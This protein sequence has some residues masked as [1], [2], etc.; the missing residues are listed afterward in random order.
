LPRAARSCALLLLCAAC[1]CAFSATASALPPSFATSGARA[2]QISE[3]LGGI[4]IDQES[5]DVYIADS[6]NNR[7]EKFSGEG[8]F[9]L[10]FGWGVADGESQEL[11]TC[12]TICFKGLEGAGAGEFVEPAGIAVDNDP[13][14]LSHGDVYVV[15][16]RNNRVQK[17]DSEGHFLTMFGGEVNSSTKANICPAAEAAFCQAG[18]KGT[19]PG[20]FEGLAGRAVAVDEST[21]TVY[22]ADRNRIQRFSEEGAAESEITF[23]EETGLIR[24]LAIDSAKDIYLWGDLQQGVHKYDQSGAELGTPRDTEAFAEALAITIGPGDELLLND[25]RPEDHHIFAF[26]PGGEQSASFDRGDGSADGERG[27]AYSTVTE[28]IYVLNGEAGRVRILTQPP[29]GP[30]IVLESQSAT[31]IEPTT[32][33]LNALAN[34]EGPEVSKCRFQYGTSTAYGSETEEKELTSGFEDQPL[35]AQL[36]G[37]S[38]NTTYHFRATCE[39]AAK[40]VGTGADESFTTLPPVSIDQTSASQ[41]NATSARLEAELNPHGLQS[42][43]RFEYGRSTAYGTS[44]PV[45]D[46]SFGSSSTDTAVENLI[47]ELLPSTTYH[48]RVIAHNALGT[49]TGPDRSFTTQGESSILPD[50]RGW[51]M[52]SPPNKHG[53]PVEPLTAAGGLIQTSLAGGA[54]AYVSD[55]PVDTDPPANRSPHDTQLIATRTPNGWQTKDIATPHEE[56]SI[57]NAGHPSEYKFWAEDLHASIVEPEGAEPLSA[58]TTERTPYRREADGEYVP[59]IT[60][61]NVPAGVEFGGKELSAENG[62]WIEGVNFR[63]AT[64]DLAHVVLESPQAL[65]PGFGPGFEPGENSNLYELTNGKL[66]LISVLPNGKPTAEAGV[67]AAVALDGFSMRGAIANDG[68]RVVFETVGEHRYL[69]DVALGQTLQLDVRQPGAAGGPFEPRFQAAN[70]DDSK[71]LFTDEAALT[72]DATATPNRPDLYMCEVKV[73]A[74][75]LSCAL[76]DLSVDHNPGEAANVAGTVSAI[77]AS[78]QHVYFAADGVLTHA[79][80]IR[81][82]AAVPGSCNSNEESTC[83]LYEYDTNTHHLGLVAV[84]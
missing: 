9:I 13:L 25:R 83:N 20:Q 72:P 6:G 52:V 16:P 11:Q 76:S 47:Q 75:Q 45:P 79:P 59:L 26:T 33:T 78:G 53:A 56:L 35:E 42:E 1:S 84:L 24:N 39:N 51:E 77:D 80:N 43:Y 65:A 64:P 23:A 8:Q 54:F 15:D 71:V 41:V 18:I 57:L 63:T 3:K 14:S 7:I 67:N 55:G 22:V 60:A 31:A 28:A 49:V 82:E 69:N 58:Q 29:P 30:F 66:T 32:A 68:S 44:V 27:I 10:A 48:Y 2:G 62:L 19:G 21:G 50:G 37:L 17:F 40:E 46:A 34:P 61:S 36:T 4:A 74:G 73:V 5:G 12:T 70:S 81:G 38:P